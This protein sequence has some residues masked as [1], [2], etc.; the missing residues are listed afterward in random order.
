MTKDEIAAV[1]FVLAKFFSLDDGQY[2]NER[3]D[4]E[5]QLALPKIEAARANGSKGGRPRGTNKKPTGLSDGLPA[6]F[7][8]GTHDEPA[9]KAPYPQ[10]NTKTSVE[11][12]KDQK[13][14]EQ[15]PTHID[16]RAGVGPD[17][18]R[19]TTPVEVVKALK[20]A[21]LDAMRMSASNP[22]LIAL[23]DAGASVE[24]FV[25]GVG[26]AMEKTEPFPYLLGMVKGA[27]TRAKQEAESIARGVM[28]PLR[29]A[30]PMPPPQNRQEAL[31][32]SNIAVARRWAERKRLE[33]AQQQP[34]Q[35][36]KA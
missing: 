30:F 18:L 14:Q 10:S 31:E 22:T 6:G 25:S 35:G 23:V 19:V 3:A 29:H 5:I 26:V 33:A 8:T 11:V 16:A 24:E 1:K 2:R 17:S 34:T 12:L 15:P 7:P 9:S 32:A 27:R 21:G 36:A 20:A 4:E 13:P 28:P